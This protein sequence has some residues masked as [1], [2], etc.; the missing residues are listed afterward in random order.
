MKRYLRYLSLSLALFGA[1]T[2]HA[3]PRPNIYQ[4]TNASP[5]A[6]ANQPFDLPVGRVVS[7]DEKRGT[8]TFLWVAP[9]VVAGFSSR[10]MTQIPADIAREFVAQNAAVY[11]LSE[12]S[13][14]TTYVRQVHD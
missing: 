8:P 13:L 10:M 7:V 5:S 11:G 1:S 4:A 2:V 12:A 14:D 6:S 9:P 3:G